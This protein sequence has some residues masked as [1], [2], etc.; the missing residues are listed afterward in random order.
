VL[1]SLSRGPVVTRWPCKGAALTQRI[2]VDDEPAKA[3]N[4]SM[5]PRRLA[6]WGLHLVV[7]CAERAAARLERFEA[8]LYHA[9]WVR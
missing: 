6:G 3:D 9:G 7:R 1:R 8:R 5:D 4:R 2:R